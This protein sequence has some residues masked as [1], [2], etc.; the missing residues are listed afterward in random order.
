MKTFLLALVCALCGCQKTEQIEVRVPVSFSGLIN[1]K[2]DRSMEQ[3]SVIIVDEL[4]FGRIKNL[5]QTEHWTSYT[6]YSGDKVVPDG[7]TAEGQA[8][9][10]HLIGG[11]EDMMYYYIGSHRDRIALEKDSPHSLKIL[12]K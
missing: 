5:K 10:F 1:V 11:D 9:G 8:F 7:A 4:G 12:N 2:E 3:R 6:V